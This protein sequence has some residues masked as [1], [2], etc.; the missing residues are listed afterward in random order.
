M[1]LGLAWYLLKKRTL[2]VFDRSETARMYSHEVKWHS[3]ATLS[4]AQVN[5]KSLVKGLYAPAAGVSLH[6]SLSQ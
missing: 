2:K 6:L 4:A 3:D 5:S 1:G